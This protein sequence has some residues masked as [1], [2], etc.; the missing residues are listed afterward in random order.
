[1]FIGLPVFGTSKDRFHHKMVLL[2]IW[3]F[4][5]R[6]AV[7]CV[8]FGPGAAIFTYLLFMAT[9]WEC[10]RKDGGRRGEELGDVR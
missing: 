5:A 8:T 6:L 7:K 10:G 4:E 2:K 3:H 1:M 9:L